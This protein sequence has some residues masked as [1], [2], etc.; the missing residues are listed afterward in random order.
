M[1]V[2]PGVFARALAPVAAGALWS[3]ARAL[4]LEAAAAVPRV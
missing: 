2:L 1:K 3:L 4:P